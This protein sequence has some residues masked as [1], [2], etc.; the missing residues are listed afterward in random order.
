MIPSEKK[1]FMFN[2]L[3]GNSKLKNALRNGAIIIDLR[4]PREFDEG[5]IQDS[6]NIPADRIPINAARI[7]AMNRPVILCGHSGVMM[8]NARNHLLGQGVKEV[9]NG[10][11]WTK[12]LNLTRSV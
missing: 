10:G 7:K 12:V 8:G 9:Y 1:P 3:F 11:S 4:S 2:L 6:I 5:H